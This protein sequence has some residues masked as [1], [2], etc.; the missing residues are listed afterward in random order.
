MIVEGLVFAG[1]AA[2][3]W[4]GRNAL[5]RAT[6]GVGLRRAPPP[7]KA[8][9]RVPIEITRAYKPLDLGEDPVRWPSERPWEL[10]ARLPVPQWPSKGWDDEHFG[11]HWDHSKAEVQDRGFHAMAA[12]GDEPPTPTPERRRRKAA[13]VEPPVPEAEPPTAVK[14]AKPAKGAKPAEAPSPREVAEWMETMGL[15]GAVQE[16]MRR[17]GW[18]FREAAQFLAKLRK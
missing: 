17:T 13:P 6:D 5:V 15:A 18:D 16:V 14:V 9:Q 11:K 3:V 12:R 1:A 10:A 2:L 7:D 4:A 8:S